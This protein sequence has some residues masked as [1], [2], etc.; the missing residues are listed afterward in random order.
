MDIAIWG[1]RKYGRYII[2]Q[3]INR[4]NVVVKFIIDKRAD[5]LKEVFG[6]PV[7]SSET[8]KSSF[9]EDVEI[10]LV[11]FV[12]SMLNIKE[13]KRLEIRKLGIVSD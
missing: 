11:A 1:A 10:V 9:A 13:L 5:E 12:N 7:V 6:I 3:L 8:F 4:S 2:Q